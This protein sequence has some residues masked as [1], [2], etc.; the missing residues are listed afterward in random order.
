MAM[1]ILRNKSLAKFKPRKG[2]TAMTKAK[3]QN[4]RQQIKLVLGEG[5]ASSFD[6]DQMIEQLGLE[7]QALST[8]AGV[9]IMSGMMEQERE[10]LAGQRYDRTTGVDRWGK[11]KGYVIVGGQKASVSRPRLR[12]KDG[13]EVSLTSY[14][15]FQD[16]GQRTQAVFQRLVSGLSCRNYPQAIEAVREGYGI[17]KS[18]VNREMV[19]ATAKGLKDLCERD[20]SEFNLCALLIDGVH[21]GDAVYL[22][23][24]GV[25]TNGRK[26][27]IGFREGST[28][29][30]DVCVALLEDMVR[31]GLNTNVPVLVVIDGSK[32]LRSA[33]E[34][35]FGNRAS[36]QRC[37]IHKRRNVKQHLPDKYHAEYE[38]KMRAAYKMSS[39]ADAKAALES[40][41]RELERLNPDATS[42]LREGIEET[43]TLH[44]LEI[45]T[46]LRTSLSST[47]LIE[48]AFSRGR[49]VMRNVKRWMNSDQRHRW[50]A[51]ALLQAEKGFRKVRGYKSMTVLANALA[52]EQQKKQN[53]VESN[54]KVA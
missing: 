54:K 11:Q 6:L 48:S 20:L 42:S 32:A 36:V 17:S 45:P 52:L 51:T 31:R 3:L 29:N 7:L 4:N 37:Q 38:R 2:V 40:V 15:R 53:K 39:Y 8:S 19:E 41:G 13:K 47:N 5:A 28:E 25:E 23:A 18:V 49:N 14:E 1:L 24:L 35:F 43:L 34:R 10:S 22:V 27:V 46:V 33:V 9:L 12:D 26:A 21:L 50:I 30:A 44:R 16:P